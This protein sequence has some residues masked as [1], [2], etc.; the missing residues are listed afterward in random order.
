MTNEVTQESLEAQTTEQLV[1]NYGV[2]PNQTK[3]EM[4][5]EILSQQD[6]SN[7]QS[8]GDNDDDNDGAIRDHEGN[9]VA[10]PVTSQNPDDNN[11]EQRK[12]SA[13]VAQGDGVE[14]SA[15]SEEYE[16][17]NGYNP[18]RDPLVPSSRVAGEIAKELRHLGESP[19]LAALHD[20]LSDEE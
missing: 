7:N 18:H 12:L 9:V 5:Q 4:I 19:T 11:D 2:N 14:K 3:D 8:D 6:S 13:E 20:G 15:D 10:G 16:V 17:T 1:E